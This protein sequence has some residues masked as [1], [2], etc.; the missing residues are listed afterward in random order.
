MT[1]SDGRSAGGD[2][3]EAPLTLELLADLHAGVFDEQVAARLRRRVAADPQAGAVLAA[4]DDTVTELRGVAPPG[5]HPARMPDT[6]AAGL[7]A[8]LVAEAKRAGYP[9]VGDTGGFETGGGCGTGPDSGT[10]AA[11][12]PDGLVARRT[13]RTGWAAVTVLAAAAAA[14]G[15]VALSGL[16][17]ETTGTPQAGDAL[18]SATVVQSAE[19]LALTRAGLDGALNQA[20]QARDYGPL[21]P[22]H[23][24]RSCLTA[25]DVPAGR[26]PLGA[27]EVTLDGRPGVLLVLP[28]GQIARFRL[29][30][31]PPNC[32]P[33]NPSPLAEH[34]VGR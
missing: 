31:V 6:V 24:L 20:L 7:D 27:L 29:L 23:M 13:R 15:V 1:G 3:A 11:V 17:W 34:V 12:P 22:P 32:G 16:Q 14:I 9:A 2:P 5:Q 19:P 8:A 26:A 4:L 28:T 25:N 18:G 10:V 21:S 30:V 33:N